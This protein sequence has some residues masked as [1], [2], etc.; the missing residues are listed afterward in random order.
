MTGS[1]CG[2]P[3]NDGLRPLVMTKGRGLLRGPSLS[4]HHPDRQGV[5]ASTV[6]FT[7]A[8]APLSTVWF[9]GSTG[10]LAKVPV[11][12]TSVTL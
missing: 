4:S 9:T 8:F 5:Y 7:V 12:G 11:G 10:V 3:R 6:T 1:G 2:P